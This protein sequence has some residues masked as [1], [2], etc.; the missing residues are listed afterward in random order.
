MLDVD[1]NGMDGIRSDPC[2][3][4]FW[5]QPKDGL[6][7]IDVNNYSQREVDKVGFTIEV[8]C[9]GAISQFSCPKLP[10]TRETFTAATMQVKNGQIVKLEPGDM[11]TGGMISQEKWGI[12]TEQFTRVETVMLSPNHWDDN[13]IGNKH[14]F[15]ILE[16]CKNPEPTR[17]IYNEFLH[18]DLDKHRKVFEVLG[19]KTKCPV[20][21]EQ[22]S[23]VGFS[24][25]RGDS[26]IV[27]VEGAKTRRIYN[28]Q[29]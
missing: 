23:G 28:V 14:W 24:S 26:V 1:A 21:D 18:A 9:N 10:R 7:R 8:E 12:K 27:A 5:Q 22:L 6:Y 20:A 4:V 25:T 17:G 19:D 16:G 2:E 13:Q 15:F 11:M 29:F 3:N